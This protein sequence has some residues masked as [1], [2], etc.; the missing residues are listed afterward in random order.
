MAIPCLKGLEFRVEE[1][2]HSML[3][4]MKFP[5]W[6]MNQLGVLVG[7]AE[8][9]LLRTKIEMRRI[10]PRDHQQYIDSTR[11][12]QWPNKIGHTKVP[13]KVFRDPR[14]NATLPLE[15]V[16]A[17]SPAMYSVY[18]LQWGGI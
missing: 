5:S 6:P 17:I 9:H 13:F 1:T 11:C 7:F 4:T 12:V 8:H 18:P 14:S 10:S 2:D 3:Y 16:T 15:A